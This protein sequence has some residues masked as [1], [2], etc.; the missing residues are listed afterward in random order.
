M[1]NLTLLSFTVLCL[2]S[3]KKNEDPLPV[4]TNKTTGDFRDK[5]TGV[6]AITIK[7]MFISHPSTGP[8]DTT[9]TQSNYTLTVSYTLADSFTDYSP[10]GKTTRPALIFTYSS[11]TVE[12]LGVNTDGTLK[13]DSLY[14][15]NSGG[16][17][18]PDSINHTSSITHTTSTSRSTITGHRQ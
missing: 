6:F 7:G 8:T 18:T 5:Y 14:N 17:I 2:F 16:F 11:G 10:S 4:T 13:R 3:C 1:K 12:K 9:I 15:V